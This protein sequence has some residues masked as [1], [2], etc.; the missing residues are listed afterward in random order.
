[1]E[2]VII[3]LQKIQEKRKKKTQSKVNQK[4]KKINIMN[5][6]YWKQWRSNVIK[7]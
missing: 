6:K 3:S 2:T 7:F 4:Y 1:M 5:K